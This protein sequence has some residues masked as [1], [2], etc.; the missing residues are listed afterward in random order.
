MGS[1]L[2][3]G[4]LPLKGIVRPFSFIHILEQMALPCLVHAPTIMHQYNPKE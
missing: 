4:G 2:V 1:V 3:I